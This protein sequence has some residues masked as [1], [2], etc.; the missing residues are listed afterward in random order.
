MIIDMVSD[1][2][3]RRP[4]VQFISRSL[5]MYVVNIIFTFPVDKS[6]PWINSD[7][8]EASLKYHVDR[9]FRSRFISQEEFYGR[10]MNISGEKKYYVSFVNKTKAQMY[11]ERRLVNQNPLKRIGPHEINNIA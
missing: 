7:N 8:S 5:K 1:E 10:L 11:K 3:L 2:P 6:I 4:S 9:F